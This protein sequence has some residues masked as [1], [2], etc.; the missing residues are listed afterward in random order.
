MYVWALEMYHTHPSMLM[1][2]LLCSRIPSQ[3][4]GRLRWCSRPAT[5]HLWPP[6]PSSLRRSRWRWSRW[7]WHICCYIFEVH[8]WCVCFV[9][10][11]TS[12]SL[13]LFQVYL[14]ARKQEQHKHQ[15][16][17]KMLSD[18]VSQI[19][20]VSIWTGQYLGLSYDCL[21]PTETHANARL[22]LDYITICMFALCKFLR[23]SSRLVL[24]LCLTLWQSLKHTNAE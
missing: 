16:S 8:K 18:E 11:L 23:I 10:F 2:Q 15:Q 13:F 21:T 9:V 24:L 1:K 22:Y 19:Q 20:E 4:D 17:L 12:A 7:V 3:S 14:E 5:G 6:N